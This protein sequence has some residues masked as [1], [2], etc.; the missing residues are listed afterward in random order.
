MSE[1]KNYSPSS[2]KLVSLKITSSN[3]TELDIRSNFYQIDIFEDINYPVLR[4]DLQLVDAVD[5]IRVLPIVGEETIEITFTSRNVNKQST[6]KFAVY[7]MDSM[8]SFFTN[9]G[10]VYTL[11]CVSVEYYSNGQTIDRSYS[12]IASNIVK[13]VLWRDLKTEKN[14]FI[15]ATT[16]IQNIVIPR[17]TPFATIDFLRQRSIAQR[18]SGGVYVFYESQYGYFYKTLESFL[19][20]A[21]NVELN[22]YTYSPVV[23]GINEEDKRFFNML[24]FEFLTKFN[25]ASKI[26]RG[27]Y[28]SKTKAYDLKT[29]NITELDFDIVKDKNKFKTSDGRT[30]INN[31]PALVNALRNTSSTTFFSVKDTTK[32]NDLRPEYQAYK[33]AFLELFNE[34]RVRCQVYGDNSLSVGRKIKLDIPSFSGSDTNRKDPYHGVY[35]ITS[36]RHIITNGPSPTYFVTMDCNRLGIRNS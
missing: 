3:G 22:T 9:K 12:D 19:E 25:T 30:I 29:K 21:E 33:R 18:S 4:A 35:V 11:K 16:G 1:N 27:V 10:A 2:V 20:M 34:T 24:N 6:F 36:L 13:D 28:A 31:S 15:E 8:E 14:V 5:L 23:S 32:P 17:L 26:N 7:A